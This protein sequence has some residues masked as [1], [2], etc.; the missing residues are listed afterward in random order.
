MKTLKLWQS[1][2][3]ALTLLP[4][5]VWSQ[6]FNN[7]YTFQTAYRSSTHT[8]A[9]QLA[10]TRIAEAGII[11]DPVNLTTVVEIGLVAPAGGAMIPPT[12]YYFDPV[13][14]NA[15]I[16]VD[17]VECPIMPNWV[18]EVAD[19][20][21]AAAGFWRIVVFKV[22][23]ATGVIAWVRKFGNG[24]P[25]N[26][27]GSAI[28]ADM[29]G[30]VYVLGNGINA[31]GFTRPYLTKIAVGGPAVLWENLYS[32]PGQPIASHES[33]DLLYNPGN[34][35]VAFTTNRSLFS[36]T[37]ARDGLVTVEVTNA[38]GAV[39]VAS[40]QPGLVGIRDIVARD[41]TLLFNGQ[42]AIVGRVNTPGSQGFLLR[43]NAGLGA[44][45]TT[46][47]PV[48]GGGMDFYLT[49]V[50]P[51]GGAGA[52]MMTSFEWRDAAGTLMPGMIPL[53]AIGG[54]VNPAIVYNLPAPPGPYIA[55]RGLIA[56]NGFTAYAVKGSMLLNNTPS[57]SLFAENTPFAPPNPNICEGPLNVNRFNDM[58]PFIIN[59]QRTPLTTSNS[60]PLM[61]QQVNGKIHDCIGNS[62]GS[63]RLA[64]TG[65]E[66]AGPGSDISIYPN[67]SNGQFT[68]E[69]GDEL[70]GQY[71][72]GEVYNALGK[73]VMTFN[74]NTTL[75]T[76]DLSGNVPGIYLL[77]LKSSDGSTSETQRLLVR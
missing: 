52:M 28:T 13:N 68:L 37:P 51:Y 16:A 53:N 11:L 18:I 42:Y 56:L 3:L 25:F 70:T 40:Q 12:F 2:L 57:L 24:L 67:P 43:Y 45:F 74:V 27:T 32:D 60:I 15:L 23:P 26:L 61:A 72:T 76:I 9:V 64:A 10:N 21:D 36:T 55:S 47:Y 17:M 19:Y 8:D 59:F 38:A 44:G 63:F 65:I 7:I 50:K 46:V 4:A 35:N 20:F 48:P 41:M 30:N 6:P 39:I 77:R 1:L 31:N 34:T 22:N 33:V 69:L 49:G 73:V 29:A 62:T 14:N 5:T 66:E 71:E 58:P 54:T 75:E